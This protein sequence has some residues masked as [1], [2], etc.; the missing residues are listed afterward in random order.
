MYRAVTLAVLNQGVDPF[1]T[2]KVVAVVEAITL[3]Q[4]TQ[5][6][7]PVTTLN[8]QDVTTE[9]RSPEV[10]AAVSAVSAIAEVR[11]RLTAQQQ[12]II[13]DAIAQAGGIVVE[14]RDIGRS[15]TPQ[16]GLKIFMTADAEIRALRRAK[17]K[18]DIPEA[19]F[20]AAIQAAM[21]KRDTF[22]STRGINPL[23]LAPD[24]V[25]I[26]TTT[27]DLDS[28]LDAVLALVAQRGMRVPTQ[29]SG[30]Q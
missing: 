1:D 22:D 14:G 28:T 8:G 10:S 12:E 17:E 24:A 27:L 6:H 4:S 9:I 29:P 25:Q 19:D 18:S 7:H 11:K 21:H 23:G 26:D 16:A 5:P 20:I 3:V 30:T 15:V 2:E 13:A